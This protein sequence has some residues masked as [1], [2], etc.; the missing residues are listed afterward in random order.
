MQYKSLFTTYFFCN[1]NFLIFFLLFTAEEEGFAALEIC[2]VVIKPSIFGTFKWHIYLSYYSVP[3]IVYYYILPKYFTILQNLTISYM[4]K[5][6]YMKPTWILSFMKPIFRIT[7]LKV[8]LLKEIII[9]ILERKTKWGWDLQI[10]VRSH[11][12]H[13]LHLKYVSF[14]YGFIHLVFFNSVIID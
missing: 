1:K 5:K 4:D 10:F 7:L 3:V 13:V 8:L 2:S 9:R 6:S 12:I 11:Q 14:L